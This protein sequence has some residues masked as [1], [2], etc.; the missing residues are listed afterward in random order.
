[1]IKI[2]KVDQLHR[3][4]LNQ[5]NKARSHGTVLVYSDQCFHCAAMK[6]QWEEMK[7][8]L[9]KTPANI[10]EINSNDLPYINHPIKNVV[11]GFPTIINLNDRNIMPFNEERTVDN[12]IRFVQENAMKNNNNNNNNNNIKKVRFNHA[13]EEPTNNTLEIGD[14][15]DLDNYLDMKITNKKGKS[16]KKSTKTKKKKKPSGKKPAGK[17]PAGPAKKQSATKKKLPPKKKVAPKKKT[18]KNKNRRFQQ[19]LQEINFRH[20][21]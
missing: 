6:P 12:F 10:Y 2:N 15:L 17:K 21:P 20:R 1:M 7:R 16:K 8:K 4:I 11:D 14:S 18:S 13:L 5:L 9:H 19:A 3:N